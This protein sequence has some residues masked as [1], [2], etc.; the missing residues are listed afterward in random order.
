MRNIEEKIIC[1]LK[2]VGIDSEGVSIKKNGI[3]CRGIRICNMDGTVSPIIYYSEHETVE[4]IM[5]R[6]RDVLSTDT[7]SFGVERLTDWNYVKDHAYLSVQ[8]SGTED[9][10][11]KPYLN[12]EIV[13]RIYLDLGDET[14]SVKVTNGLI[15][16]LGITEEEIW[17]AAE[18]NTRSHITVRS[19]AEVLGIDT[20]DEDQLYV[21][22]AG[23]YGGAAALFCSEVFRKFCDDHGETEAYILPSSVDEILVLPGSTVGRTITVDDLA[24]MVLTINEQQVAPIMRLPAETF[25]YDAKS[26]SIEIAAVAD[27]EVI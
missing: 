1:E 8:K 22:T 25:V 27:G 24:K 5:S 12:L 4:S 26:D 15:D 9:I 17:Q 7:T 20:E 18:S 3:K 16:Q 19:M 10:V 2:S 14:G 13:L 11:K 23:M 21:V 6:I